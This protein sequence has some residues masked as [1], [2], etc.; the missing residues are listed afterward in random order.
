MDKE[1]SVRIRLLSGIVDVS[2]AALMKT[3]DWISDKVRICI[4]YPFRN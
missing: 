1:G 2:T 3:E 4:T